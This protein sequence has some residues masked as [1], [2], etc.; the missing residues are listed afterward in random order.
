MP[1]LPPKLTDLLAERGWIEILGALIF[2]AFWIISALAGTLAKK[3]QE[4]EQQ[5]QAEELE[6]IL[7]E[8]ARPSPTP[9]AA[10]PPL[11]G[12]PDPDRPPVTT[13]DEMER[14]LAEARERAARAEAERRAQQQA[15]RNTLN[16]EP[17]RRQQEEVFQDQHRQRQRERRRTERA[18]RDGTRPPALPTAPARPALAASLSPQEETV[19]RRTVATDEFVFNTASP[20]AGQR[21]QVANAATIR[22]WLTPQTLRQQY[23]LTELFQPPLA[24]REERPIG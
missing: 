24:L 15:R 6:R 10:P 16:V 19:T 3:K 2:V 18:R 8:E 9:P 14:R 13:R 21:P 11:P 1:P 7:R 23:I 5:Q 22:R 4:Q 17:L 20:S 12:T